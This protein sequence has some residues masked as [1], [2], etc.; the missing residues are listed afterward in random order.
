MYTETEVSTVAAARAEVERSRRAELDTALDRLEAAGEFTDAQRAVVERLAERLTR[1]LVG[2]PL[3]R[4]AST[5][6]AAAVGRLFL[7]GGDGDE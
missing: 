7:D 6:E 1:Q 2:A 3:D 4:A 5:T